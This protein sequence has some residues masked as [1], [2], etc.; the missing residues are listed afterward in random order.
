MVANRCFWL[1]QV[2]HCAWCCA[3]AWCAASSSGWADD[4][5]NFHSDSEE[6]FA[7]LHSEAAKSETSVISPESA[8]FDQWESL[9]EDCE[10]GPQHDELLAFD[11]MRHFGFKHSSTSGRNVGK[12]NPMGNSSWLNRPYHYDW[13]IGPLLGDDLITNRVSQ[14]NVIY[15][16]LRLGWDFDYFWGIEWRFGW[17]DPGA[18]YADQEIDPANVSFVI[19]D[20][21]V[22]Y[23]PWGDAK[24]RPYLLWGLGVSQIDFQDDL[25]FN[26]HATLATMPFGAGVKFHQ[27]PWLVWRLEILDNLA[28]G[29]DQISTMNNVSLTAGMELR[30]GARPSSYWPWR[31]GRVVW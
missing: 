29:A 15:G 10:A 4:E 3:L 18:T 31:P 5:L 6:A 21:D 12:G 2:R 17:A 11:W 23:Y 19:S 20:V 22:V 9:T 30:F 27:F 28:F 1:A 13:F 16:G 14:D 7:E 8:K 25:G 26:H 24:V